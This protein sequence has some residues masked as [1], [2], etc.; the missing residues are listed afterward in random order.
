MFR[1]GKVREL[2]EGIINHMRKLNYE[3]GS[4]KWVKFS[5]EELRQFY[6]PVE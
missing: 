1:N 6:V 2:L 5:E 4:Q 3:C